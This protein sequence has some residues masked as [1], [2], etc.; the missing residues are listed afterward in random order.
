MSEV[1]GSA[2]ANITTLALALC[3]G[4]ALVA[5]VACGLVLCTYERTTRPDLPRDRADP[6]L[7]AYNTEGTFDKEIANV[8]L[9]INI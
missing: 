3:G 5:L 4:V 8:K 7:C 6:P 9:K 2:V 1:A